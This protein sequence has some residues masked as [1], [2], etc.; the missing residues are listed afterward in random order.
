MIHDEDLN[1]MVFP[2]V[3]EMT[4]RL[5]SDTPFEIAAKAIA[6][7][8]GHRDLWPYYSFSTIRKDDEDDVKDVIISDLR[9]CFSSF[10][11]EF[12]NDP[13]GQND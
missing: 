4:F 2:K 3:K 6:T 8:N 11:K 7:K 9:K 5:S 10:K 12:G 1:K 13:A